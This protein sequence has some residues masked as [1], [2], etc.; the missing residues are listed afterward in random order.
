MC[1]AVVMQNFNDSNNWYTPPNFHGFMSQVQSLQP[2][3][4]RSPELAQQ[5]AKLSGETKAKRERRTARQAKVLVSLWVKNFE[6]LESSR[7]NQV[8]Q[9]LVIKVCSLGPTKTL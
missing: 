8:W 7:C 2:S 1:K 6:A 3:Y 4:L 5:E 9:K